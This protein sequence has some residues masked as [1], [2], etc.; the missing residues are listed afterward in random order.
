M[1]K[2]EKERETER[3]KKTGWWRGRWVQKQGG[4]KHEGE[5]KANSKNSQRKRTRKT[6]NNKQTVTHRHTN[7]Y[8]IIHKTSDHNTDY[9]NP[10]D[11][12]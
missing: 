8:I 5:T 3:Q 4:I 2:S 7:I 10:L 9:L 1:D 6:E 12:D 11:D